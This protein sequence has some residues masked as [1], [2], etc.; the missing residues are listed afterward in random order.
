MR[1]E[2]R[3]YRESHEWALKQGE[4]L[5]VGITDHAVQQLGDLTFLEIKAKVG[6]KV[7]A[8]DLIA[9]IESVKTVADIYAPIDGEVTAVNAALGK[10]V[11]PLAASPF[12]SG[13]ILK[14]RPANAADYSSLLDAAAYDKVVD[15]H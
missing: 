8:G 13:W 11:E 14:I 15:S 1:P 9:E 2:D 4:E 3:R 10:D 5:A 7:K 6:Q 12:D